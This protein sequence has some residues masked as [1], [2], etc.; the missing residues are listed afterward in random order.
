MIDVCDAVYFL[1]DWRESEGAK[2][3][4]KYAEEKGIKIMFEEKNS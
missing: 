3:E 2:V 4:C 1:K